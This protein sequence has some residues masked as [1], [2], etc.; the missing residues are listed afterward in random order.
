MHSHHF[1]WIVPA[2]GGLQSQR[3]PVDNKVTGNQWT[4]K[5]QATNKQQS[6]RQPVNY[7]VTGNQWT[8]KSQATSEQQSHRQPVNNKPCSFYLLQFDK[9]VAHSK[10][11]WC[12]TAR[13]GPQGLLVIGQSSTVV[14]FVESNACFS[15]QRWYVI[16]SLQN[17][18]LFKLYRLIS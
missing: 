1:S 6:L 14:L 7:K 11:D 4:T 8:T 10:S 9:T 13:I 16:V 17:K 12:G 5:S 3:Q 2:T 15:K 18:Y